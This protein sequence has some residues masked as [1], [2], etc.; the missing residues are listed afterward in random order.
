MDNATKPILSILFWFYK[1]IQLCRNRLALLRRYNPSVKIFGLFGGEA[2]KSGEF[3]TAL[4]PLLDDFFPFLDVKDSGWKWRNGDLILLDW[5]KKRGAGLAWDTIVVVQWDM[6]LFKPVE[7][8]FHM[9][10]KNEVLLS[11]VRPLKEVESWWLWTRATNPAE[12]RSFEEFLSYIAER[13][14]YRGEPLA[15]HFIV[16][17]LPRL[18]W[19][20]FAALDRPECGYLE[21]KI[22]TL[23]KAFGMELCTSHPF[24]SWWHGDPQVSKERQ[25]N[26][27]LVADGAHQLGMGT[28]LYHLL[29]PSGARIF[30]PYDGPFP[31]TL[32]E[33][34]PYTGKILR[35]RVSRKRSM[36]P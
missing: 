2:E 34:L 27:T 19:E 36:P 20:K 29:R 13:L 21:Y 28:I 33:W 14:G 8:L 9:L 16:A 35:S 3:E 5:Y 6:L 23:A 24:Q 1:D 25:L 15:S 17:C 10:K 31:Q 7:R 11:G 30:H 32:G 22:P 26:H 12:R 18:F 4:S